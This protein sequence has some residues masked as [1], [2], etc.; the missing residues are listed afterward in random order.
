MVQS[1]GYKIIKRS[2]GEDIG[3]R[4]KYY[5]NYVFSDTVQTT[6]AVGLLKQ[7]NV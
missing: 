1:A 7:E 2:N 5:R 3:L 4:R 6:V